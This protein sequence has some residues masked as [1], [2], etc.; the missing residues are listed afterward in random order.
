MAK[1]AFLALKSPQEQNLGEM[2]S[3]LSEKDDAHLI[4]LEDA[5]YNALEPRRA[6]RLAE[7]AAEIHVARDDLEARGFSEADLKIGRAMDYDGIVDMIMERTD[8]TVTL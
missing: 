2:V 8:R 4:L 5:V 6:G 7:V 1:I 3:G